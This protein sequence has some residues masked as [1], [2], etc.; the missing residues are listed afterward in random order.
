MYLLIKK[1]AYVPNK[2][3]ANVIFLG[4]KTCNDT[5]TRNN[6]I[7][8]HNMYIPFNNI[9]LKIPVQESIPSLLLIVMTDIC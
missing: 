6:C 7:H 3:D 1:C 8:S 5:A 9:R 4:N 2:Y